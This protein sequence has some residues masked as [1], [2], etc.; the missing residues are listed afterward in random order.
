MKKLL[1]MA[2]MAMLLVLVGASVQASYW[3]P[4]PSG[5]LDVNYVAFTG[6]GT[7]AIFDNS[8]TLN[9]TANSGEYLPLVSTGD[10]IFFV[11]NGSDWQLWRDANS[12]TIPETN[13]GFVLSNSSTF[14]LAWNPSGSVGSVWYADTSFSELASGVYTVSWDNVGA[15]QSSSSL[16]QIDAVPSAVPVPPSAIM[17]FSGILGLFGVRRMRR[18]G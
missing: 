12:D 5:D 18:D 3:T 13:T 15:Q 17:L 16:I 11:P 4:T 9:A 1:M 7:Y 2:V 10:T 14:Q 6:G 8:F